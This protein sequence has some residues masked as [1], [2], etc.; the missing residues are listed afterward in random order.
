MMCVTEWQ[1]GVTPAE[2]TSGVDISL[3]Y[4]LITC[5]DNNKSWAGRYRSYIRRERPSSEAALAF[6][7][8]AL[9]SMW[10][11]PLAERLHFI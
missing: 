7:Q 8:S 1:P 2:Q 6:D 10:L 4:V 3:F 9:C 11:N 5:F